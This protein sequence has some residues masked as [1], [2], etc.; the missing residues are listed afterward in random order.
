MVV[1]SF[2]LAMV[3]CRHKT[4]FDNSPSHP[5]LSD[6]GAFARIRAF[7]Q[8]RQRFVQCVGNICA[9]ALIKRN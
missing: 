4:L 2:S 7:I 6:D 1:G 3:R 5:D 9:A 8:V